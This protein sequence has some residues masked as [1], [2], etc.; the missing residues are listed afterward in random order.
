MRVS[1]NFL[2]LGTTRIDRQTDRHQ[3]RYATARSAACLF[4]LLLAGSIDHAR[5]DAVSA[6]SEPVA[7]MESRQIPAVGTH[8]A[9]HAR[10]ARLKAEAEGLDSIVFPSELLSL[11]DDQ[12]VGEAVQEEKAAFATRT[13]AF[14]A[15]MAEFDRMMRLAKIEIQFGEEKR[16]ALEV[17]VEAL[18]GALANHDRLAAKG[19]ALAFDRLNLSQRLV[20]YQVMRADV[21]LS[22]AKTR[23]DMATVERSANDLPTQY[24]EQ[25]KADM[26]ALLLASGKR[27][28]SPEF[29][30]SLNVGP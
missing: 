30:Q 15:R 22:L 21:N 7:R 10:Y 13:R 27:L 29:A 18:K 9:F 12:S 4:V 14:R 3:P 5:A 8:A 25:I 17:H 1:P 28:N 16:A 20:D 19:Q 6:V 26:A 2:T 23:E 11:S 24:R